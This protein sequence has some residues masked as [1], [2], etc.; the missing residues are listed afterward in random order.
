MAEGLSRPYSDFSS[1]AGSTCWNFREDRVERM[2][3]TVSSF[4]GKSGPSAQIHSPFS[5]RVKER[6]AAPL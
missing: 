5:S 2:E 1:V 4:R 6:V 3:A